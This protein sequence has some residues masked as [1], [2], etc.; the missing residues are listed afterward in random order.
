MIVMFVSKGIF[1]M[2]YVKH[3]LKEIVNPAAQMEKPASNA[4]QPI[5]SNSVNAKNV[6]SHV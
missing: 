6:N 3:V 4:P 2:K 1:K 5:I